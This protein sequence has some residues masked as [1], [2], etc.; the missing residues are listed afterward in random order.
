MKMNLSNCAKGSCVVILSVA[1]A[2][3]AIA[4]FPKNLKPGD[5]V[6]DKNGKKQGHSDPGI[7]GWNDYEK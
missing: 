6:Y 3:C 7:F 2:L 5:G 4:D 1:T